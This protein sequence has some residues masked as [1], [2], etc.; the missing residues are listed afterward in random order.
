MNQE[1]YRV[2]HNLFFRLVKF[3]YGE[4]LTYTGISE[5]VQAVFANLVSGSNTL[6]TPHSTVTY[7]QLNHLF[8][9]EL[10][11]SD[12]A[13]QVFSPLGKPLPFFV[14]HQISPHHH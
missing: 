1:T 14:P 6:V 2:V 10:S 9:R 5:Y 12:L 3:D 4:P 8:N 11:E 7:Q 13:G